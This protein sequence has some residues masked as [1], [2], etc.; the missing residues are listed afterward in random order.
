MSKDLHYRPDID[1]L[2]AIAVL[3]VVLFHIGVPHMEGG[4]VGVDIFFVISGFLITKIIAG[5][6]SRGDFSIIRFYERRIR[7]IFPALFAMLIVTG[8]I[9]AAVLMPMDFKEFSASAVATTLFSSNIFFWLKSDYFDQAAELKPL[10][11][12]WSLAVEEQYYTVFPLFM[13]LVMP[14]WRHWRWALLAVTVAS[15]VLSIVLVR[16]D[17]SMTFYL[18]FTRFWELLIGS[19]IAVG[20]PPPI[21]N[22]T[23]RQLMSLTGLGM[24]LYGVVTYTA[25]TR[26][27]G[28]SAL[29]PCLGAGLIL[30]ADIT[31]PTLVGRMLSLKPMI[32]V[33]LISYSLYLW[34][35]PVL[36][37]ARYVLMRPLETVDKLAIFAVV[38]LLAYLSW[39][40]VER[41]FRRARNIDTRSMFL[42]A[43][44]MMA[45]VLAVGGAGYLLKGLPGR[46]PA[47]V[48]HYALAS[49]DIN[50]QRAACD[51]RSASDIA[52]GRVCTL[53]AAVGGGPTFAVLGDSFGDALIPGIDGAGRQAGRKGLILTYSGCYALV[54]VDQGNPECQRQLEASLALIRRTPSIRTVVLVGRWTTAVNGSRFGAMSENAMFIRDEAS[55]TRSYAENPRVF[56]RSMARTI[57]RIKPLKVLVVAYVPEQAVDVPRAAALSRYF[58]P[59]PDISVPRATYLARQAPVQ[60]ILEPQSRALDF[61]LLDA[62]KVLCDD[63]ACIGARGGDVLYFDDNHLSATGA[64]RLSGVIG[65]ALRDS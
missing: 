31:G 51:R 42:G 15:L 7:R 22:R 63:R 47:P 9:A 35:W 37:F 62:G 26:F 34:H 10:L 45:L 54:G 49:E 56:E 41:P 36:V 8:L 27:P 65:A 46:F 32:W 44:T 18:P 16:K 11:H 29:L 2:R 24:I 30:Y 60:A 55:T 53:G 20:L 5:E 3:S 38:M 58:N 4:Y 57:G 64:R 17:P 52:A 48:R 21:Q 1:G 23:A 6:V 19:L 40:F 13:A 28:E 25:Q 12:T 39:R 43:A 33:G 59:Q 61:Q 14:R 50:P